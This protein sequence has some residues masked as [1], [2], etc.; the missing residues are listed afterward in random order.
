MIKAYLKQAWTLMKQNR[1]F[2][3]I[4]IAG[5]GLSIAVVM[6]LFIICYVKFAPIYPEYNRDRTLVI[7][8][9]RALGKETPGT[10]TRSSV[11]YRVTKELLVGLP[12]LEAVGCAAPSSRRNN[13]VTLPDKS[14]LPVGVKY[15]DAGFWQVFTFRFLSG[16]PF[17]R[18]EVEA[19]QSVAVISES[20]AK[21][22]FA[23]SDV[24][25]RHFKCNGKEFKV[26]GV[27]ADVSH[28]T[29]ET[30]ADVWLPIMHCSWVRSEMESY[31]LL[32]STKVF[33][34]AP[35]VADKDKLRDEVQE[36]FRRYNLQDK[37]WE[38]DLMGQ[39][40]VYWKSLY[41]QS[42]DVDTVELIK[43]LLYILMALLV[44]PALNLSGMI[45]SR[46]NRR[47]AELGMRKAYGAT[48]RQLMC[49]VLC[50]NLLLTLLGGLL[51]LLLSYLIVLM[52]N[53]WLLTLFDTWKR[54][55]VTL[56]DLRP[57]MLF[58]PAVLGCAF[59][60]T[61]LLNVMSALL[62]AIFALKHTIVESIYTNR[63]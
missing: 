5:T 38:Y 62:P 44:I 33:M 7:S 23:S 45:S 31:G 34:L 51:G 56:A 22:L 58:N 55:S 17:G 19:N 8:A 57:E 60:L 1:L 59:C 52:A 36:L 49:Q 6:V 14:S 54:Y 61:L 43:N 28:L 2:T 10:E 27:V 48:N 32:G 13:K 21:R 18:Q 26:C 63:N 29:P 47:L 37:Y 53:D 16:M 41:R 50:E 3:G 20:L 4:Y 24:V 11:A 46:M 25:G 39:P 35:T 40:D 9:L 42:K 15:V 30:V 12:H